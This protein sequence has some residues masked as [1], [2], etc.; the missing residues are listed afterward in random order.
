MIFLGASKL[1][2]LLHHY[3]FI[4]YKFPNIILVISYIKKIIK[5]HDTTECT[6]QRQ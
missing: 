3:L 4:N 2:E 6:S 1:G 5:M